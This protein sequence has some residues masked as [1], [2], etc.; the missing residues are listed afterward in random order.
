MMNLITLCLTCSSITG[1]IQDQE[2]KWA[3]DYLKENIEDVQTP[4]LYP[5]GFKIKFPKEYYEGYALVTNNHKFRWWDEV[6]PLS[7]T[8]L[9]RYDWDFGSVQDRSI[10]IHEACHI[11]D[12]KTIAGCNCDP[13]FIQYFYLLENGYSVEQI[14]LLYGMVYHDYSKKCKLKVFK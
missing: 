6:V 10:L 14:R 11:L 1:I 13:Y 9:V 2:I 7:G 5:N 4:V 8:I 12:F 3:F